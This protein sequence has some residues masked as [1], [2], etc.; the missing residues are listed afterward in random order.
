MDL[1]DFAPL[2][3]ETA[4]WMTPITTGYINFALHPPLPPTNGLGDLYVNASLVLM[5]PYNGWAIHC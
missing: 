2:L 4:R 3:D 5:G 1:H